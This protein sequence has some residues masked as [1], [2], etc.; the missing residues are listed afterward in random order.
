MHSA[1]RNNSHQGSKNA[2]QGIITSKPSHEH[3]FCAK[4]SRGAQET[5]AAI[6]MICD[7][8]NSVAAFLND[9]HHIPKIHHQ[10]TTHR[11]LICK[12]TRQPHNKKENTTL[13]VDVNLLTYKKLRFFQNHLNL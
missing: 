11:N 3:R 5:H 2:L 4:C 8:Q 10:I 9:K 7:S 6:S 12:Q 13:A 1:P